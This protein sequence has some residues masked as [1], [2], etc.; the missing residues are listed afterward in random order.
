MTSFSIKKKK[1]E[2]VEVEKRKEE[3]NLDNVQPDTGSHVARHV[4]RKGA[5]ARGLSFDSSQVA[6]VE[7][8]RAL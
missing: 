7:S 3:T 2:K 4:S 5:H 1:S 6:Q 8:S